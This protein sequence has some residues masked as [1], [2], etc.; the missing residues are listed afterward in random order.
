MCGRHHL[1]RSLLSRMDVFGDSSAAGCVIAS[2]LI[3]E[4]SFQLHSEARMFSPKSGSP[5]GL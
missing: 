2:P 3:A 1:K 4:F 5:L